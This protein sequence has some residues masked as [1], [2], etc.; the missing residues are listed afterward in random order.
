MVIVD[1]IAFTSDKPRLTHRLQENPPP[2][3]KRLLL[4]PQRLRNSPRR[5]MVRV[6]RRTTPIRRKTGRARTLGEKVCT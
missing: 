1:A 4:T 6:F 5:S 2:I 3:E